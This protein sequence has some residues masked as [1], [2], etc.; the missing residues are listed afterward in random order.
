MFAMDEL[1]TLI[2]GKAGV[3]EE[4]ISEVGAQLGRH[5]RVR[6]R[7]LKSAREKSDRG[8]IAD[9]LLSKLPGV[10]LEDARG[11]TVILSKR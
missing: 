11:N 7:F 10:R 3:T 2:V 8:S 4:F 1:K 9:E 6:I 5:K